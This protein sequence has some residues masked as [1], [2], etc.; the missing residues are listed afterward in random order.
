MYLIIEENGNSCQ[1]ENLSEEDK[2][3]SRSGYNS[4]YRYTENEF[5]EIVFNENLIPSCKNVFWRS[6]CI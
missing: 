3:M 5:E 1:A 4:I 6:Q 2:E